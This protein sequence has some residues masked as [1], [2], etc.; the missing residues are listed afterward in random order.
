MNDNTSRHPLSREEKIRLL[1]G[2]GISRMREGVQDP[3]RNYAVAFLG[4]VCLWGLIDPRGWFF[5]NI[6]L[7]ALFMIV[8]RRSRFQVPWMLELFPIL[9]VTCFVLAAYYK[10]QK[11]FSPYAQ[12]NVELLSTFWLAT[13]CNFGF[14]FAC[15]WIIHRQVPAGEVL[16]AR[17][18]EFPMPRPWVIRMYVV[19]LVLNIG[20]RPFVPYEIRVLVIS[21]GHLEIVAL[22]IFLYQSLADLPGFRRSQAKWALAGLGFWFLHEVAS[23]LFGTPV[24]TLLGVAPLFSRYIK[25]WVV[26]IAIIFNLVFIPLIQGVKK[27]VRASAA[28]ET[29]YKKEAEKIP[30]VFARNVDRIIIQGDWNAYRKGFDEFVDRIDFV[31]MV[32]RI[33]SNVD[34]THKFAEGKTLVNS[35]LWNLIPRF[36]YPSKPVTGGSS[37]LAREYGGL[38]VEPGTSVGIGPISEFYINFGYS[39]AVV[40]MVMMGGVY[41]FVIGKLFKHP[42][43]PLGYVYAAMVFISVIRPETNLADSFG[44]ALRSV[45]VWFVVQWFFSMHIRTKQR[46]ALRHPVPPPGTPPPS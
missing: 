4:L 20:V 3:T 1:T 42:L 45:V 15:L 39:G 35:I 30:Q 41:G 28:E 14:I 31:G 6:G 10:R 23:T 12:I 33:K 25:P 34:T 11:I 46:E 13:F 40:C 19:G 22:L 29:Y 38:V 27:Q 2:R 44:G 8:R 5:A 24:I 32:L 26:A 9:A 37:E 21:V 16:T 36:I 7:L 17:V 43:Q 18:P